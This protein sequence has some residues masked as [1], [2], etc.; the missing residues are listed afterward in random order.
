MKLFEAINNSRSFNT[1]RHHSKVVKKK[2][3]NCH[4][5][6]LSAGPPDLR[7]FHAGG[8]SCP[9]SRLRSPKSPRWKSLRW[10]SLG[11]L[12]TL[13]LETR[14]GEMLRLAHASV[15]LEPR[16]SELVVLFLRSRSRCSDTPNLLLCI[17]VFLQYGGDKR[18][19]RGLVL[20]T[21]NSVRIHKR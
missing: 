13:D 12:G 21:A 20:Y 19:T 8:S 7:T 18:V 4:I 9:D 6:R 17:S 15:L 5:Q 14:S 11:V 3:A 1:K 16:H 2:K 10:K